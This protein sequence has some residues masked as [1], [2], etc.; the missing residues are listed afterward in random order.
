MFQP[1]VTTM[2]RE[3]HDHY[4]RQ[5]KREG[6]RSR[7][8]YK[9]IEIDDRK[10]AINQGDRV[11]DLGAAPGAWLQ[12]AARRTGEKGVV[13][14]LDLTNIEPLNNS[15]VVTVQGD[16]R[17]IEPADL[18]AAADRA[19]GRSLSPATQRFDVVLSDM[20]PNTS[21][22]REVDHYRSI[23]LCRTAL[24]LAG[25][26]LKPGGRLV[27][28]VFEGA[29]YPDLLAET[30]QAFKSVKGFT[31]KASRSES[32][33]IYIIAQQFIGA[34]ESAKRTDEPFAEPTQPPQRKPST[35]WSR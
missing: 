20:A 24:H 12:V 29:A 10:D 35:G 19:A 6:Y 30:K 9:L 3:I 23:A 28:K 4:F 15:N 34:H 32:T 21:D 17:E 18:L 16:V 25:S 22:S 1:I 33:E 2:S 7:A 27:M 14:G 5:A 26:L 8:A 13:V 31:P 11:L